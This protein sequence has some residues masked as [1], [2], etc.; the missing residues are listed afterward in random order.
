MRPRLTYANVVATMALVLALGGGTV[1]AA[2]ELGK[3]EVK[4]E[5]IAPGAVQS[6]DLSPKLL[7]KMDVD[8]TGSAK[9]GPKGDVNTNTSEPLPLKGKTTLKPNRKSVAAIAAEARFTI[10]STD[11]D[12]FCSPGVNLLLNGRPTRIFV[13]PDSDG[14]STTLVK[15]LGGDA[16]GPY[17]LIE[18]KKKLKITAQIFGDEDCTPDSQLDRLEIR[19]A[20]I[21]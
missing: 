9:G 14:N 15:S 18:P 13:T 16:G 4:S 10:A 6:A 7:K 8:I 1:Y 20:Q 5:N 12:K 19:I 17:G 11:P 2:V 21:R 3:D